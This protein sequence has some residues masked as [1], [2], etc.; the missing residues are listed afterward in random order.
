[1]EVGGDGYSDSWVRLLDE[2]GT[3]LSCDQTSLDESLVEAE[4]WAKEWMSD[5]YHQ[6]AV[7]AGLL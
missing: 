5:N 6:Q 1:M 4:T 3:R 2:G 7:E